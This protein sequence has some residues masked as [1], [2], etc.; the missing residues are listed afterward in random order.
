MFNRTIS[1]NSG[2]KF[3][4]VCPEGE[5]VFRRGLVYQDDW[6]SVFAVNIPTAA[7]RKAARVPNVHAGLR[8]L[9]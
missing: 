8:P 1:R 3:R 5:A 7:D 6:N 4:C 9:R 2:G